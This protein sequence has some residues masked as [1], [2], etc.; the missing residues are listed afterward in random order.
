VLFV[1]FMRGV[2]PPSEG[3]TERPADR[4]GP[5]PG[6]PGGR[7]APKDSVPE[8]EPFPGPED[9]PGVALSVLGKV[10]KAKLRAG[11]VKGAVA[12]LA[13]VSDDG[14]RD[15][16]LREFIFALDWGPPNAVSG[17]PS[18]G[19][20]GRRRTATPQDVPVY[21]QLVRAV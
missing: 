14:E 7:G 1:L 17:G 8:P 18:K 13:E 19:R 9:A 15:E 5:A 6:P 10:A 2:A 11:D 21:M 3:R 4:P 16:A 20:A 12:A